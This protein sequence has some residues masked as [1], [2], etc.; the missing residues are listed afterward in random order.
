M[1][2]IMVVIMETVIIGIF[3]TGI[4]TGHVAIGIVATETMEI[5]TGAAMIVAI[6]IM[7]IRETRVIETVIGIRPIEN[8]QARNSGGEYRR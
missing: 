8:Y 4:M 6:E 5:G 2:A 3:A 7:G 1:V